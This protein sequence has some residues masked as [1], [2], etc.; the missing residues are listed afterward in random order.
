[1]LLPAD[2]Y[3]SKVCYDLAVTLSVNCKLVDYLPLSNRRSWRMLNSWQE[4]SPG[5]SEAHK[6]FQEGFAEQ[7]LVPG[8]DCDLLHAMVYSKETP[9]MDDDFRG[10]Y[11]A[12]LKAPVDVKVSPLLRRLPV[13]VSGSHSPWC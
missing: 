6:L 5:L 10:M 9:A 7:R 13:T 8:T 4:T 1:M 3:C 12:V 11:T 2:W